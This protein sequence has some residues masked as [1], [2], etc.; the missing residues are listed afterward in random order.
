MPYLRKV[1]KHGNIIEDCKYTNGRYGLKKKNR[2]P[3]GKTPPEQLRWQSKNN[4]RKCWR[5]LDNNFN[6]GDLWVMLSYPYKSK[7]STETVRNN[8]SKFLVKARK[9]Y[10]KAGKVFKYI[11]SAGRG[12]RGAVH[13]HMVLPKFDIAAIRDLWSKIVNHGDWV[14]TEF[15][16]LDKKKDYYKLANYIIKNSEETFYS[17]DPVYKKRY[18]SSRNLRQKRVKAKVI[19]KKEWKKKPPERRGYY[20][21]KERS[22]IG[23]NA[24]GYPMQ[25]TVYVKLSTFGTRSG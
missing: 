18:C 14:K 10:K 7:P 6:P 23:Y 8:M 9:M 21:D 22:Y 20:I 15:Q 3:L 19:P 11:F 13:F 25:Y 4:V 1:F 5:L 17:D 2:K 24:Y 12:K 16:P